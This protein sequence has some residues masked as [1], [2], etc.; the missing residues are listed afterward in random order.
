MSEPEKALGFFGVLVIAA[1]LA[2]IYLYTSVDQG[3]AQRSLPVENCEKNG[4]T[5]VTIS[6]GAKTCVRFST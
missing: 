6:H 3:N 2:C 1:L 5:L 4:G